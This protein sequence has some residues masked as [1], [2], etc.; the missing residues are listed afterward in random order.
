MNSFMAN[1]A[2]VERKWYVVDA[3][4]YTLGRLA[5]EV[6][7]VL[8]GKNKPVF[9]PHV[10]TG[11]YVIVVNADKIKVTGKKL[12]QKIYYHHS[13]YVGGMKETTLREM[14]AKK[15][16]KVVEL[17]VKGMLPKG[18]LGREMFTKLHVYAGAEHPHAAQQPEALTF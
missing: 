16:E 6:A 9:T 10:D 1:P 7:K 17:A 3:T 11:D 15:P 5:S 14:L 12:D 13:D 8:R 2:K 18:P 4:G